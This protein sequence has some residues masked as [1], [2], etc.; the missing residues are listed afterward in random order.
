MGPGMMGPWGMGWFGIIFIILIV[1]V[2]IVAL[3]FL[4]PRLKQS[5]EIGRLEASSGK[6]KALEILEERY[7]IPDFANKYLFGPL[8]I[9]DFQWWFSPK[10]SAWL[11]G[12]AKMRPR[13]MAKFGFMVLNRGRWNETQIV[14]KE[15]IEKSTKEHIRNSGGYWGYGYL[16]WIGKTIIK[17]QDIDAIIASGNGGQ[18]IYIFPKFESVA[19]FTGGNYGSDLSSQPDQMLIN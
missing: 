13:D 4:L 6:S 1:I 19:V 9:N 5:M 3:I 17:N 2:V 7:S 10:K 12:N 16:W 15:W 14:S 18:K 8:G 11:A